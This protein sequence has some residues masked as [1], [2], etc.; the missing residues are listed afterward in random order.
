[1]KFSVALVLIVILFMSCEYKDTNKVEPACTPDLKISFSTD[2]K[3]IFISKCAIP[4]CHNHANQS[5]PFLT[6]YAEIKPNAGD[7]AGQLSNN[8]MPPRNSAGGELTIHEKA[9]INCW[10]TQGA[11]DN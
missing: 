11:L 10:I 5:L 8:A 4:T 3:P 1:M 9:L 7:I 6:T 2:I